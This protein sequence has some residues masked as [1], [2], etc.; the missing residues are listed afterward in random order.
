MWTNFADNGKIHTCMYN[1]CTLYT[2]AVGV[3]LARQLACFRYVFCSLRSHGTRDKVGSILDK[4]YRERVFEYAFCSLRS[5][6]TRF[7]YGRLRAQALS[8]PCLVMGRSSVLCLQRMAQLSDLVIWCARNW[9]M[10]GA[11]VFCSLRSHGTR[12]LL[13]QQSKPCL[14]MGKAGVCTC[15]VIS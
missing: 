12:L 13:T 1:V 4:G 3:I 6:G 7:A 10:F 14:V 11:T 15:V 5:H 8:Q 2:T 9:W